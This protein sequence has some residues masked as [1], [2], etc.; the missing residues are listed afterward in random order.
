MT[1]RVLIIGGYGN[2][3]KIIARLLAKEPN[4]VLIVAGRRLHLAKQLASQLDAQHP[5]EAYQCDIHHEFGAF[6]A[7]VTPD[8]V[9]HTSGP[10]Q[11]Q[12]YQVPKACIQQGC[13]YIDLADGR[14]YVTHI[15]SLDEKAKQ[16]GVFVCSGASSLPGLSSAII[17]Q[18]T[19][20]FSLLE[21]AKYAIATAQLTNQG[22][23]TTA[24]VLSYAGKSFFSLVKGK[25]KAIYGWQGLQY[26]RFWRLGTRFLGNC[27]VPDLALFPKHYPSLQSIQFKAGLELKCLQL[28]L[29]GL[30]WLVRCK[31]LPSLNHFAKPMLA[32]SHCFDR[33]GRDNTGFY[34]T[35]SGQD[36][37]GKNLTIEFDIYAQNGDGRN[38][39][40]IP[41][42][43][44]TKRLAQGEN[45]TG[46]RPCVGLVQLKDYL[47]A[48]KHYGLNITWR[49]TL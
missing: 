7:K 3:G 20:H 39:P 25:Q 28:I 12:S 1:K 44:L 41:A 38:I 15:D 21:S 34:M 32:I 9:I 48:F 22:L 31:L 33:F 36:M 18:Y 46:A 6:L 19:R 37:E 27:D 30:S 8:I 35:L 5:V 17:E 23:A 14:D 45:L 13:H 24:G 16:Q 49:N 2:F 43:L 47:D 42:I 26:K 10:F 11:G 4:I 29:Y 40:C